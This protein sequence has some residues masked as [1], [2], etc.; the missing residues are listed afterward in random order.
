MLIRINQ[1]FD[2][3]RTTAQQRRFAAGANYPSPLLRRAQA[4][5]LALARKHAPEKPLKGPVALWVVLYYHSDK[6]DGT[7]F[8]TT[9]PDLDNTLKLIQDALAKAGWM[10][11]DGAICAIH[12]T[13]FFTSENESVYIEAKEI[14]Q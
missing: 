12:A 9:R 2:I 13:K 10:K 6:V 11:D 1:E 7:V 14:S 4:T 3:P 5:W 8:K